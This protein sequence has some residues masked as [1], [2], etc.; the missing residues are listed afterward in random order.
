MNRLDASLFRV[1]NRFADRTSWAHGAAV[2]YAKVGIVA[3]AL[4]LLAGWWTARRGGNLDQ[5][6]CVLWAGLG[7]VVALG[8]NQVIGGLV[9]RARP[10]ET[11]T[12]AHVLVSRTTDFSF[13]SDHAV[14]VG[15]V[16]AGLVLAHRRLGALAIVLAAIMAAARVYVGAHYPGDVA[17]GVALGAAVVVL[18]GLLAMPVLR[19]LVGTIERSPLRPVVAGSRRPEEPGDGSLASPPSPRLFPGH[20]EVA[21]V[22]QAP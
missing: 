13:P 6:A 17:A 21:G 3:F 19:R 14:A 11:L 15:A 20:P 8:L 4:M 5:M 22:S 16:A 1:M 2:A 10:Y 12:D 9:D 7:A 18:G